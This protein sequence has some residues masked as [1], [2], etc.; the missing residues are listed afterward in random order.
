MTSTVSSISETSVR[1]NYTETDQM[2][3]STTHDIWFGWTW[4]AASTCGSAA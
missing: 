4:P 2:G 3:V 1:V